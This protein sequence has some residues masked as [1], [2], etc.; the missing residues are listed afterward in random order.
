MSR[1]EKTDRPMTR[2]VNAGRH[3]EDWGGAVNP[4][5]YRVSTIVH[6]TMA[7]REA[8]FARRFADEREMIYGRTGTPTSFALEDAV[9]ELEGGHRAQLYPSG[10]AAIAGAISAFASAGDSILVSDSVYGPTR[11]F[12]DTYLK[13]M[14]VKTVYYDPEIGGGIAEMLG[15]E[16]SLVFTE[17]PGSLTFEVQDIPAIAAAARA[18]GAVTIMDNTWATPLYCKPFELGVDLS[19]HAGTKYIVGHSDAMLGVVVAN[20]AAWPR[21]A[22]TAMQ[23]GMS[24]GPDDAYLGQRGLR[25]MA[26]RLRQHQQGAM[27][28]VAWLDQ[29]PEIARVLY[30]A[31]PG[32]PGHALWKRDF[33]GAS[34]LLG[35]ELTDEASPHARAIVDGLRLF[36]IGSSWG[37]YESLA[38]VQKPADFRTAKPWTGHGALLRLHIGLEDPADLI[39]DLDQSIGRAVSGGAEAKT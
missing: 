34:G 29:R 26:V 13:R 33:T 24:A 5:V 37:G 17:S 10:L 1:T 35:F 32:D 25:T 30:P 38:L 6:P 23:T 15:P 8:A 28:I 12:C 2:V 11:K 9:A 4:P 20:E 3:P 27:E 31:W 18:A 7:A 22:D 39:A 19:V 14:G 21:L 16:V 36:G